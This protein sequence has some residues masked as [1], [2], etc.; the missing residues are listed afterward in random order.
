MKWKSKVTGFAILWMFI[1]F[2]YASCGS[3]PAAQPERIES[4]GMVSGQTGREAVTV[5]SATERDPYSDSLAGK[6]LPEKV[7]LFFFYEQICE[8]C[9]ELN[10]FYE[11]LSKE[12]PRDVRDIYPHMIYTI[13]IFSD[14]GRKTY[15][16]VTDAMG[17]DRMLLNAPI[18]IAGGRVF[19]GQD[20]ISDNIREAFLT[21]GED[22]FVNHRFYNP[23]LRKTGPKLFEDYSL[24]PANVTMVYF[25]RITCPYCEQVNPFINDLP[26][27][28]NTAGKQ[29][30]LDIIRI[31]TRS[32]NN[33]ERVMAFFEKY[34]VPDIDR[35]VPIIFLADS[36][37]SGVDAIKDELSGRLS[38]LPSVNKLA[39]LIR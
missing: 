33:N 27:R 17:L 36:Y 35:R 32:G 12:L 5:V 13:N 7:E 15:E 2:T 16:Q 23:S 10:N 37:M 18:L 38:L 29:I 39:E 21:A 19:Q 11:T 25:Y 26:R 31:N 28:V 9:N 24:N 30:P 34:K 6:P 20:T 22:I 3:K 8:S 4:P 1:V 14:R